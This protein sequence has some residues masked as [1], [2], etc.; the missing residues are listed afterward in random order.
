MPTTYHERLRELFDDLPEHRG[1]LVITVSREVADVVQALPE[2]D[3]RVLHAHL[4]SVV[5]GW[6]ASFEIEVG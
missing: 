1:A 2:D 5:E 3:R 4:E 6:L